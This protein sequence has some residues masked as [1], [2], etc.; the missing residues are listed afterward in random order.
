MRFE[1]LAEANFDLA[2]C[3]QYYL[4]EF[5][6]MTADRFA[7]TVDRCYDE[8][9]DAPFRLVPDKKGVRRK[10]IKGFPEHSI[11]YIVSGELIEVVAFRHHKRRPGFWENRLR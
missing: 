3:L 11:S 6:P 2:E 1:I 10:P 7:Q 5:T 8:I 9:L 4:D